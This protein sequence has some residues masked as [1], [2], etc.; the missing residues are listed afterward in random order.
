MTINETLVKSLAFSYDSYITAETFAKLDQPLKGILDHDPKLQAAWD[1]G[2]LLGRLQ[3]LAG[4]AATIHE[5]AKYLDFRSGQDLRDFLD[6]DQEALSIW[7][8]ERQKL[9]GQIRRGLIKAAR[10]GNATAIRAL[11]S[12]LGEEKVGSSHSDFSGVTI[13]ELV[14]LTGKS[15]VTIH[16]WYTKH[17]LPR[18]LDCAFDLSEFI[19]WFEAFTTKKVLKGKLKANR[20]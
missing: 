15:R 4:V 14:S 1:R 13:A 2:N 7:Q 10:R 12:V 18:N 5:L 11:A 8:T 3:H 17:G 19:Q 9:F 6:N 16:N 20:E